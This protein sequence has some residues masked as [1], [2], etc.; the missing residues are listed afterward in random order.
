MRS[1][2]VTETWCLSSFLTIN[3]NLVRRIVI[4]FLSSLIVFGS[5]TTLLYSAD[6]QS[7]PNHLI[8]LIDA[9]GSMRRFTDKNNLP[10]AEAK[11]R[12]KKIWGPKIEEMLYSI[13]VFLK[14][15]KNIIGEEVYNYKKDYI[16]VFLFGLPKFKTVS[17]RDNFI[18]PLHCWRS[19]LPIE[20]A[21]NSVDVKFKTFNRDIGLLSWAAPLGFNKAGRCT[22]FETKISNTYILMLTDGQANWVP[23]LSSEIAT[24][25]N[26]VKS[27]GVQF[28]S[29]QGFEYCERIIS[30]LG[31]WYNFYKET[32]VKK[33]QE[34]L[35]QLILIKVA[36]N[37]YKEISDATPQLREVKLTRRGNN[38]LGTLT[39]EA[40]NPKSTIIQPVGSNYQVQLGNYI[41]EGRV[42]FDDRFLHAIDIGIGRE[43]TSS[44]E[45]GKI[46]VLFD[47]KINDPWYGK[48]YI[49]LERQG[50]VQVPEAII[51]EPFGFSAPDILYERLPEATPNEI[52]HLIYLLLFLFTAFLF[53]V[54][55]TSGYLFLSRPNH[56]IRTQSRAEGRNRNRTFEIKAGQNAQQNEELI[57]T[58][59]CIDQGGKKRLG[60]IKTRKKPFRLEGE[61]YFRNEVNESAK[62]AIGFGEEIDKAIDFKGIY[63]NFPIYL[64]FNPAAIKVLST[65]TADQEIP[66]R[67]RFKVDGQEAGN[68]E[69][70]L[71]LSYIPEPSTPDV[72]IDIFREVIEHH[73]DVENKVIGELSIGSSA[74][75]DLSERMHCSCAIEMLP[76]DPE[77]PS[78]NEAIWFSDFNV[79]DRDDSVSVHHRP[80]QGMNIPSAVVVGNLPKEGQVTCS[81]CVDFSKLRAP[82]L[83]SHSYEIVLTPSQ[84]D[85]AKPYPALRKKLMVEPDPRKTDLLLFVSPQKDEGPEDHYCS[86][87]TYESHKYH[88]PLSTMWVDNQGADDYRTLAYLRIDNNAKSGKGLLKLKLSGAAIQCQGSSDEFR[89][90]NHLKPK[91]LFGIRQVSPTTTLSRR[92]SQF[93]FS[94]TIPNQA[95]GRERPLIFELQFLPANLEAMT[96]FRNVFSIKF[97]IAYKI[98]NNPEAELILNV[99]TDIRKH[100]GRKVLA[101]DF[102][103][104]A[105]VSAFAED[106]ESAKREGAVLDLQSTFI[107]ITNLINGVKSKSK[108]PDSSNQEADTKFIPSSIFVN[109]SGS[110]G[111][112]S[113][114]G[115]I[116][117]PEDRGL[118]ILPARQSHFD[119]APGQIIPFVK[120]FIGDGRNSVTI[121][122]RRIRDD[123]ILMEHEEV[124][125]EDIVVSAYKCLFQSYLKPSLQSLPP[126]LVITHPN[127]FSLLHLARL[128]SWLV[129]RLSD[130]VE[131]SQL[132]LLSESNAVACYYLE[133]I[134][135]F[136]SEG[137]GEQIDLK[138]EEYLFV[139]DMGAGTLDISYIR[140]TRKESMEQTLDVLY[141]QGIP[142]AGNSL[143]VVFARIIHNYLVT[144][145]EKL[146][147]SGILMIYQNPIVVKSLLD[148]D[149]KKLYQSA[150]YKLKRQIQDSI[151]ETFSQLIR[152]DSKKGFVSVYFPTMTG[153]E[154]EAVLD[155]SS[156]AMTTDDQS[157]IL[158]SHGIEHQGEDWRVDIP[159]EYF[160]SGYGA[161][162]LDHFYHTVVDDSLTDFWYNSGGQ[163]EIDSL[164]ISGRASLFADIPEKLQAKFRKLSKG[165]LK[166]EPIIFSG[167][168]LKACVAQGSLLYE[169]KYRNRVQINDRNIWGRY[170]FYRV[171]G[172]GGRKEF[173]EIIGPKD[174]ISNDCETK[175]IGDNLILL[176][177][178]KK[179]NIPLNGSQELYFCMTFCNDPNRELNLPGKQKSNYWRHKFIP[180]RASS[181]PT[182]ELPNTFNVEMG[183]EWNDE[184]EI[185]ELKIIIDAPGLAPINLL[186][187]KD[188]SMENN[189]SGEDAWPL[190]PLVQP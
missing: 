50:L 96:P 138:D 91:D 108:N 161:Q 81:V 173:I 160:K 118:S 93:D 21:L 76:T 104:S 16:S 59:S 113:V 102:G 38:Y 46:N 148:N 63:P 144:M 115:S 11:S 5:S 87:S 120:K 60:F 39:I 88:S 71:R 99:K 171:N 40:P 166:L 33:N 35:L 37:A 109:S 175:K 66:Y 140:V 105:I 189:I 80:A 158:K 103:T 167:S 178:A 74:R 65:Y 49:S 122:A 89:P 123:D 184:R 185:S 9:S 22:S 58:Y 125:L 62:E 4:S 127:M 70:M 169:Q 28:P 77:G 142:V 164:I 128:K 10:L 27:L 84:D 162:M 83:T 182:N 135:E 78:V 17:F 119:N 64:F 132:S 165:N 44:F 56:K 32:Y 23:N 112:L 153:V 6:K 188:S 34:E 29:G 73:K 143:D 187:A 69:G 19:R 111:A 86:T 90:A 110:V 14:E 55:G 129:N 30:G 183:V 3:I 68:H 124:T 13:P 72:K 94:C 57:D 12:F 20:M 181:Y 92:L 136:I 114:A 48:H 52:K 163:P 151:K 146:E 36:I 82:E 79:S 149:G 61:I 42:S 174:L 41:K 177:H 47:F 180:L 45:Y 159:I 179:E 117:L 98:D 7:Y 95:P 134:Y 190:Q 106:E 150:M 18:K 15:K 8:V 116:S 126:R 172:A 156:E 186:A 133:N 43:S 157:S 139:Y 2:N 54:T 130:D 137:D 155:F 25:K 121:Q 141:R 51:I 168:G 154:G 75:Q 26:Y 147:D 170:G 100:P 53:I 24:V 67:V 31:E 107:A 101:I 131:E 85:G 176:P 152:K 1:S 145:H 97:P